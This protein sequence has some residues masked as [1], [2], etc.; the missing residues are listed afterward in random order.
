[1]NFGLSREGNKGSKKSIL[2]DL[3]SEDNK[4][5]KSGTA[6]RDNQAN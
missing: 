5:M 1:M 2:D 4:S 6:R 3:M